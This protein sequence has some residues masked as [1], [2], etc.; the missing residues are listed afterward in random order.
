MSRDDEPPNCSFLAVLCFRL[1]RVRACKFAFAHVCLK[2]R[3]SYATRQTL[4]QE[5]ARACGPA[6]S[7][8]VHRFLPVW[9]MLHVPEAKPSLDQLNQQLRLAR[10]AVDPLKQAIALNN[11]GTYYKERREPVEAIEF[12]LEALEFFSGLQDLERKATVLNNLGATCHD[13]GE[14][15]KALEYFAM[16]L[17]TYGTLEQPFGQGMA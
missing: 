4:I 11:L 16:A 13:A 9:G 8:I 1:A 10:T 2:A 14:Y 3:E 17:G 6:P 12:F 15:Q 5:Q 7:T